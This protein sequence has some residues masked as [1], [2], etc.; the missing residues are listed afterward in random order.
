MT[1]SVGHM[2][3]LMHRG[4]HGLRCAKYIASGTYFVTGKGLTSIAK[5]DKPV[6]LGSGSD[7]AVCSIDT[8]LQLHTS[9][10]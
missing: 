2:D 6:L 3:R 4:K 8:C 9:T 10:Q 5:D 7:V 1:G